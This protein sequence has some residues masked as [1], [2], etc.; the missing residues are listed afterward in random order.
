MEKSKIKKI[1]VIIV[2]IFVVFIIIGGISF[3]AWYKN[4]LKAISS[5]K[6]DGTVRVVIPEGTGTSGIASILYEEGIIKNVTAM[7][8]YVKVNGINNL[9]AGKYDLNRTEDLPTILA[10]IQNGEVAKDSQKDCRPN[11]KY[12]RRCFQ[13]FKR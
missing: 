3:F 10:H 5:N 8:I 11:S 6:Q 7:K 13:S 12:R 2:V 9:Q 4:S 1:V